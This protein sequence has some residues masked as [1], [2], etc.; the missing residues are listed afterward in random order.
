[1]LAQKSSQQR[2]EFLRQR[3]GAVTEQLVEE[4]PET[5]DVIGR[6]RTASHQLIRGSSQEPGDAEVDELG[7][8]GGVHEH[9]GRFQIAVDYALP[10]R[11]V[12]CVGDR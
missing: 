11:V 8:P 10:V 3:F 1:M 7:L 9:V 5:V 12:Q 6:R 4:R 2:S